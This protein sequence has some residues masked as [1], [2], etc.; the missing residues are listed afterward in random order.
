[1]TTI[2]YKNTDSH[3]LTGTNFPTVAAGTKVTVER[4]EDGKTVTFEAG[5]TAPK[6]IC[7]KKGAGTQLFMLLGGCSK[8][9]PVEVKV[10]IGE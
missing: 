5:H 2:T 9:N 4:M 3:S 7:S 8:A 1:M 6:Q 10:T